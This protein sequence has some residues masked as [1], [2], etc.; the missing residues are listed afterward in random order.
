MYTLYMQHNLIID[1]TIISLI[2]H[3]SY[4]NSLHINKGLATLHE[5]GNYDLPKE[6]LNV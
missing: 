5:H 1:Y 2:L 6:Y 4:N 3:D